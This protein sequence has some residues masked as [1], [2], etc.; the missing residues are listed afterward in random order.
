MLG[1]ILIP[2]ELVDSLAVVSSLANCAFGIIQDKWRTMRYSAAN[3]Y[4]GVW[5]GN[6]LKLADAETRKESD[7]VLKED[8]LSGVILK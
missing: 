5:D 8:K 6:Q 1:C 7:V 3:A 2:G 4:V